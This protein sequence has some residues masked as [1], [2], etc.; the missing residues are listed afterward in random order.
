MANVYVFSA[1]H[2]QI[3]SSLRHTARFAIGLPRTMRQSVPTSTIATSR[4][5]KAPF[6]AIRAPPCSTVRAFRFMTSQSQGSARSLF[7]VCLFLCCIL[8]FLFYK[9]KTIKKNFL[10]I[11]FLP[12]P[13]LSWLIWVTLHPMQR[14]TRRRHVIK[15]KSSLINLPNPNNQQSTCYSGQ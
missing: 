1:P 6:S 2:R 4:S 9:K 15:P 12:S 5:T 7:F 14:L 3:V 10:K 8:F 13:G 11:R